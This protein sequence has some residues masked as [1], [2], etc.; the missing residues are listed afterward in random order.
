[1]KSFGSINNA[2]KILVFGNVA[3]NMAD[4]VLA[5]I[6]AIFVTH[7]IAP[8]SVSVV[9]YAIAIY[10]LV[11]SIVQLPIARYL[12]KMNNEKYNYIAILILYGLPGKKKKF[13]GHSV[14]PEA[15]KLSRLGSNYF[16]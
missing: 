12:D 7:K 4:G 9:G 5:P 8:D 3:V 1:M 2:I 11:K 13:Q 6:F 10:W 14:R 15:F 16:N